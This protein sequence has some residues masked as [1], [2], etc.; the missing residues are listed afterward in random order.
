LGLEHARHSPRIPA[1]AIGSS[2]V[3]HEAAD[4]ARTWFTPSKAERRVKVARMVAVDVRGVRDVGTLL[5][6][7][8]K[9]SR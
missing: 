3:D 5:R 7:R 9:L 1:W 4:W 8:Y 2:L 6:D